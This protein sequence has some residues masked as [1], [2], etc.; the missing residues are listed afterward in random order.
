[1]SYD[2]N[3][4]V[5]DRDDQAMIR[6]SHWDKSLETV[7]AGRN[8]TIFNFIDFRKAFDGVH[9]PALWKI[10]RMYGFPE[11]ISILLN[12]YQDSKCAVRT[13]GDWWP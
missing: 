4:P 9:Q 1:M 10:L 11:Q 7:T 5:L 12:L 8:P 3:R 6:Y 13:N 2:R